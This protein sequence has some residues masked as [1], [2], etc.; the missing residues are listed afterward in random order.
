MNVRSKQEED[1]MP[2]T[3]PRSIGLCA[4]LALSAP[5]ALLAQKDCAT[6][7]SLSLPGATIVS[8]EP[9]PAAA[10]LPAYCK[11]K[12]IA[13]PTSDS[14]INFEVWLPGA[15]WNKVMLQVGNGGLAGSIPYPQ[16]MQ[17]LAHH[18]AVAATDDGHTGA[19]TDGSWAVGHPE[20]VI[21]FGYRAV[22]TTNVLA[23]LI[24]T[25]FYGHAAQ[26]A[27][28]NGCSEGGREALMEAQ[29]FP[30]DFNGILA[31]SAA[32]NWTG[33]MEGFAW[34][35]QALLK[36]PASYIPEK[37]RPAIEAAA[38]QACGTQAGVK[39]A[40]IKDPLA[41]HFDPSVLLCK[42]DD[43]DSCLTAPQ[44]TALQKIYAGAVNPR[45]GQRLYP[46]YIPG[47]EAEPGMPGLSYS[48]YIYGPAAPMTLD[49]IFSSS[50]LGSAVFNDPKYSSLS[51]DFDKDAQLT[52][53]KVGALDATNP[54]LKAFKAH[55]GKLLQYHGWYDGSPSPLTAVE[56]YRS[57]EHAMGGEKATQDFYKLYMVPGMMHCGTGPGPN[58]FGNLTDASGAMDPEHNILSALRGW[59]ESGRNPEQ[60]IATKFTED[61]PTKGA[62]MTRPLC[63]FPKQAVWDGKGDTAAAASFTCRIAGK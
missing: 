50:F 56:Y 30:E 55:G 11:V 52:R 24:V 41:C 32:G 58:S 59:V 63:P 57:V 15:D 46:G 54:D 45:T 23:K 62:A 1:H 39:D 31:G 61:N 40:F 44:L 42:Q 20:K 19:G 47:A 43:A 10:G 29:R 51:F 16:M 13:T 33:I 35:A 4:A 36:D 37:K 48:S 34:N 12:A 53:D 26:Y 18:Y 6:L 21:D 25:A 49:V 14:R 17:A 2:C 3:F 8:A 28:F 27:Y 7:A 38:L 9:T 60:L 22:H 5:L